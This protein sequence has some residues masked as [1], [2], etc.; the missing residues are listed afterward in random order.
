[1]RTRP[2]ISANE[3]PRPYSETVAER[4]IT[5]P[6]EVVLGQIRL[7][8]SEAQAA[9]DPAER[10]RLQCEAEGLRCALHEQEACDVL[11]RDPRLRAGR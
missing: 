2:F 5:D 10:D 1:M 11:S 8:E 6:R 9:D 7:L 4:R 3:S